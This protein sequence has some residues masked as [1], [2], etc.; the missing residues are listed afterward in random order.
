MNENNVCK[1]CPQPSSDFNFITFS[2]VFWLPAKYSDSEKNF[3]FLPKQPF[4]VSQPPVNY[5]ETML[6]SE[7]TIKQQHQN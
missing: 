5:A 7:I 6:I 4:L 2:P 3:V 1:H